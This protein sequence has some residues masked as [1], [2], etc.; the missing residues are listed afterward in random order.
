MASSSSGDVIPENTKLVT[1]PEVLRTAQAVYPGMILDLS[2]ALVKAGWKQAVHLEA[3]YD[4]PKEARELVQ[5]L[6]IPGAQDWE[7]DHYATHLCD[8]M[9][10]YR[11][12]AKRLRRQRHV[13][14]ELL[15]EEWR[16]T[17]LKEERTK[18]TPMLEEGLG[19]I[20]SPVK[21]R[22]RIR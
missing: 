8:W 13:K 2:T 14:D 4:D 6:D 5:E 9:D 22:S 16:L 11:P 1:N 3:A 21:T 20:V 12:T 15:R 10:D 7:I 19:I 18:P 17:K